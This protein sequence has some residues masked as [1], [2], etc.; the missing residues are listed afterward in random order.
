[1]TILELAK[2]VEFNKDALCDGNLLAKLNITD[3]TLVE[4]TYDEL[5]NGDFHFAV[6]V[7]GHEPQ[8]YVT[9]GWNEVHWELLEVRLGTDACNIN[10]KEI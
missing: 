2:L 8:L 5:C 1:M 4:D 7:D 10:I 3:T 9:T 6:W